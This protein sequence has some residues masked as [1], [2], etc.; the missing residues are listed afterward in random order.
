MS[1]RRTPDTVDIMIYAMSREIRDNEIS[2]TGTLSPIPASA[3]YLAKLTT[4]PQG[5]P[6]HSGF[7]GL[8][9]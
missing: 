2:C 7:S 5:P 4:A 1:A 9:L 8:A 6:G 3:C